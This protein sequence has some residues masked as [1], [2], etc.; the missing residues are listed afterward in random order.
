MTQNTSKLVILGSLLQNTSKLVVL[1]IRFITVHVLNE[2]HITP[3][4]DTSECAQYSKNLVILLYYVR[5]CVPQWEILGV[6]PCHDA[7]IG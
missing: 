3:I 1:I 2:G 5:N 7:T 6:G 4:Q